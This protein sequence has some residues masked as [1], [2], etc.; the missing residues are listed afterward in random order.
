VSFGF[1]ASSYVASGGG[2]GGLVY[3]G[4]TSTAPAGS[5]SVT[6]TLPSGTV[7]GDQAFFYVTHG[8]GLNTLTG[9]TQIA[10][11]TLWGDGRLWTKVLDSTDISTGSVTVTAGGSWWGTGILVTI[12]GV[13]SYRLVGN[14]VYGNPATNPASATCTPSGTEDVY[15]FAGTRTENGGAGDEVIDHGTEIANPIAASYLA[16]VASR[17]VAPANSSETVSATSSGGDGV[18]FD[19]HELFGVA[20]SP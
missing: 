17:Q 1:A 3:R 13:T 7:A 20:V 11:N 8:Y 19:R 4:V 12:G 2:G 14:T 6:C 18:N 16:A 5:S 10:A 9:W 15:W